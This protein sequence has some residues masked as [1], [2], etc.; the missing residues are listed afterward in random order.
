MFDIMS[1]EISKH[2]RTLHKVR[3]SS[4]QITLVIA[5]IGEKNDLGLIT[6][7]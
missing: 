2:G 4:D 7:N 1:L 3:I 5:F 6:V